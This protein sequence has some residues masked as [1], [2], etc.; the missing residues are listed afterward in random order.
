MSDAAVT[1]AGYQDKAKPNQWFGGPGIAPNAGSMVLRNAQGV[2]ADSLNYGGLVDPWLAEGYQGTSGTGQ[3]G[4]F[5]TA[6]GTAAGSGRSAIRSP[7][8]AD[9]DS[10]CADFTTSSNPTPG[11]ANQP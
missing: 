6:P 1:T 3:A 9:T 8:G 11:A 2:E 4:C 10:N 7:D 5:V